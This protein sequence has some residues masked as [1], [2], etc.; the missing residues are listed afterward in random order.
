M[1]HSKREIKREINHVAPTYMATA[2]SATNAG[3]KDCRKSVLELSRAPASNMVAACSNIQQ[4]DQVK[5]SASDS[6]LCFVGSKAGKE[7]QA[8]PLSTDPSWPGK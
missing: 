3:L 6:A 2:W 7:L 8:A 4:Q 1:I 5:L